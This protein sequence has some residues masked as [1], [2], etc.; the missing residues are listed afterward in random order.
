MI[1]LVLCFV[2]IF[3]VSSIITA[4]AL[5]KKVASS[6]VV[7]KADETTGNI[8]QEEQINLIFE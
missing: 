4:N 6:T 5:R 2:V 7:Y 8:T 1:I 3:S